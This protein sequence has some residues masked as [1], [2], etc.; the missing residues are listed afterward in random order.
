MDTKKCRQYRQMVR[1]TK[2]RHGRDF[3]VRIGKK[4]G[5]NPLLQGL[6]NGTLKIVPVK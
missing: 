6:K 1:T 4:S 2:E 5:G 3:Y